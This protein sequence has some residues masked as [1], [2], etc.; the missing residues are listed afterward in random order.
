[1]NVV[2]ND[3]AVYLFQKCG[4]NADAI[5]ENDVTCL[6]ATQFVMYEGADQTHIETHFD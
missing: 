3:Y 6:L 1:M 2:F 4:H 5:Y